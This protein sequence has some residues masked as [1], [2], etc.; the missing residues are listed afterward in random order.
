MTDHLAAMDEE[1]H[2][3][4]DETD[5]TAVVDDHQHEEVT[6]TS[7]SF[8]QRFSRIFTSS[9]ERGSTNE[10]RLI[11][12]DESIALHPD[13]AMNYILR[14]ELRLKRDDLDGAQQDFQQ[15]LII[16]ETQFQQ[17]NWGFADQILQDRAKRGLE[18]T[19]RKLHI[20]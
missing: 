9:T 11:D 3:D 6:E 5:L 16:A 19:R 14:G 7:V 17:D 10:Q 20:G 4:A 12:L 8:W 13:V 1:I 15:G 2:T 18:L